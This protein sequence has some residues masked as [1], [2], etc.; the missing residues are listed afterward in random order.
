MPN[1][2]LDTALTVLG[3]LRSAALAI[4]LPAS[5]AGLNVSLSAGLATN[6]DAVS[7]LDQIVARA[8]AALY[9]AKHQGRDLVRIA[10]ESYRTAS[11]GVRR[12]IGGG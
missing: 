8:D 4:E 3:R 7:S 5:S 6:E 9:Q 11:T 12:A 10:D 2:A 1:T